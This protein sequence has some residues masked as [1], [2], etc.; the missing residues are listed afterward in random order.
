MDQS[1]LNLDDLIDRKIKRFMGDG[2]AFNYLAMQQAIEIPAWKIRQ[3]SNFRTG[4]VMG[5]GGPSTSNLVEAADIL[6]EKGVEKSRALYG[7]P[8]HVQHQHRLLGDTIQNQ[9]RQL[10]HQLGLC[11]QCSLYRPC[12]GIDPD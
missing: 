11:D 9:R 8:R 6:R 10:H 3:V 5:S 1:R 4:L 12:H 7:A 2:A